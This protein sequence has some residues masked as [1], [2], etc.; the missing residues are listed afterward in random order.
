MKIKRYV[1]SSLFLVVAALLVI[2]IGISVF[3][4]VTVNKKNKEIETK[5]AQIQ[6]TTEQLNE[7]EQK[8]Q[9]ETEAKDKLSQELEQAQKDNENLKI[10]NENYKNEIAI[11]CRK[12]VTGKL[13]RTIN[14]E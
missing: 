7:T 4:I 3:G 1:R 12:Y 10:E 13:H 6:T 5:N 2:S 9:Q 8:L 11:S 14:L